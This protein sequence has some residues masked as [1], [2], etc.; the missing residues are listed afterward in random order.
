MK[1]ERDYARDIVEIR[2][3]MERSSKFLSLAGW[4]GIMAG[5]YALLGV[6]LAYDFLG[7]TPEKITTPGS[8]NLFSNVS[9]IT[10]LG[11][12]ILILSLGTAVVLSARKARKKR[13][14]IWNPTARRLVINMAIP[15]F[16]GGILIVIM[17]LHDLLSL[18]APLSLLFYG[19]AL[20]NAGRYT[21]D[22]VRVMGL[23]QIVLGLL[24]SWF[25]EWGLFLWAIGFGLVHIIYGIYLH[26]KYER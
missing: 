16:S 12:I 3:M 14:K 7:F 22:E 6:Y 26:Y 15:L 21:Y 2:S 19:L 5:I 23:V 11:L 20:F 4:A 9:E 1:K 10:F 13:E 24:S 18:I 17:I 8:E 25:V